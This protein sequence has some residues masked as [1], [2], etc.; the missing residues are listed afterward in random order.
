MVLR[1]LAIPANVA[2]DLWLIKNRCEIQ[3]FGLPMFHSAAHFE[4]IRTAN[5]FVDRAKAQLGHM[6]THLLGDEAHEIHHVGW[7]AL[8]FLAQLG[9]LRGDPH[10]TGV[11]VTDPHH[12]AAQGHQGSGCKAEFLGAKHRSNDDVAAR[13]QLSVGLHSD[14]AAQIVKHQGLVRLR[15]SQLPGQAGMFDAGLW[16]SSG[17]AVMAANQNHISMALGHARRNGSDADFRNELHANARV[18]IGVLEIVNQ[19]RQIFDGVDVM[20][21]RW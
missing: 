19:L 16:R 2:P 18:M 15:E 6:L 9:I 10:R 11:E 13:L 17:A 1:Y 7:I 4:P 21:R 14:A 12:D 8:K 20:V 3:T 5:H